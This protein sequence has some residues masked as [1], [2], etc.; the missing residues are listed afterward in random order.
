MTKIIVSC[1][2]K[3]GVGKTTT[4][5][6]LGIYLSEKNYRV[7]LID[8][9]PQ[10]NLSKSLVDEPGFGLYE[11]LTGGDYEP[12][13]VKL[14][15]SL[16]SGGVKLAGL[17]RSLIGEL[18][19]FTRLKDLLKGGAS[20]ELFQTYD[21]ILI[22]SPPSLGVLT[23][24]ALTA[25]DW[26]IIPMNPSLYSMQG[27]NDLMATFSKVRKNFN[28][29]LQLLG[30]IVNAFDSVPSITKQIHAEIRE[31]FGKKVF[32]SVLSKSIKIEEAIA[33]KTGVT[34][35]NSKI[36]GEVRAIG[37]ELLSRLNLV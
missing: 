10:G 26:L 2:Q 30:V 25:S 36:A 11:A 28:P 31:A 14:N 34:V 13:D 6:E 9:D 4:T 20:G 17:E 1:N 19:A 16:L 21:F 3:G 32:T 5:R 27:T 24:N 22:D 12:E 29:D 35:K 18:D 7:L 15:L 37:E 33:S 8:S 23:G